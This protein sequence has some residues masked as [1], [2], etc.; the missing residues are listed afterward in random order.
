MRLL[1]VDDYEPD[2]RLICRAA[3]ADHVVL[4]ATSLREAESVVHR[5]LDM[6]GPIDAALVDLNLGDSRGPQTYM[7]M[8]QILGDDV[9]IVIYAGNRDREVVRELIRGGA[10]E[11]VMKRRDLSGDAVLTLLEI[12]VDFK[13][14][15]QKRG[16]VDTATLLQHAL[17][18]REELARAVDR[19]SLV[20]TE[21][22]LQGVLAR[23]DAAIDE[24]RRGQAHNRDAVETARNTAL[25]AKEATAVLQQRFEDLPQSERRKAAKKYG[26]RGAVAGLMPFLVV[27]LEALIRALFGG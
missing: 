1:V 5:E 19:P 15:R 6:N 27:V 17:E 22:D 11:Y 26:T 12:A 13:A 4:E 16:D 3:G 7:R 10:D 25:S 24:L 2:R 20:G 21:I 18:I 23:Q 14:R 8:R 9:A